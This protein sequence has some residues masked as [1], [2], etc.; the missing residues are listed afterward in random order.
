[1]TPAEIRS[2]RPGTQDDASAAARRA[3]VGIIVALYLRHTATFL[4]EPE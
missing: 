3:A 1:M 2:I 4:S